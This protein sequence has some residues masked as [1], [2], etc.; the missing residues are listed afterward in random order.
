MHVNFTLFGGA[1]KSTQTIE[2]LATEYLDFI[3]NLEQPWYEGNGDDTLFTIVHRSY[4]EN[5]T[6]YVMRLFL[7]RKEVNIM[8]EFIPF[9]QGLHQDQQQTLQ[10]MS[11]NIVTDWNSSHHKALKLEQQV[12]SLTETVKML[13]KKDLEI[14]MRVICIELQKKICQDVR[15]GSKLIGRTKTSLI[16]PPNFNN[17]TLK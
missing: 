13:A 14:N 2:A 16:T 4:Q 1:D 6:F 10:A 15:P 5:V 12:A 17:T 11:K 7:D 9:F 3:S 8:P